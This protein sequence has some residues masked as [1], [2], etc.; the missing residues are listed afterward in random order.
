MYMKRM[1]GEYNYLEL[2]DI[3]EEEDEQGPM[4]EGPGEIILKYLFKN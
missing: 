1:G 2:E 4:G 3:L